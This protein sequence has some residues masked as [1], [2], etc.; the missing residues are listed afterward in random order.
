[1]DDR[2]LHVG[3]ALLRDIPEGDEPDDQDQR[4]R[5]QRRP[6]VGKRQLDQA[7]HDF[8]PTTSRGC[9][10]TRSP[11]LT[12][13]W[14]TAITRAVAG[15]PPSQTRSESPAITW[16]WTKAT[17]SPSPTSL[18]PMRP[19]SSSVSTDGGMAWAR[20]WATGRRSSAVTPS[21]MRPS[22]F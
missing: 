8:P 22:G 18:T 2:D 21:M 19:R 12:N 9:G 16:A 11:S 7:V 1:V 20:I 14:P 13:S 17:L 5:R 4:E 15:S 3:I 10:A 6:L